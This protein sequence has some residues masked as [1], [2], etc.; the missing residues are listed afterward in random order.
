[1]QNPIQK[2]GQSFIVFK[3]PGIF[4]KNLKILMS[5]NYPTVQHFCWNF[6][7]VAYLPMSIKGCTGFFLSCLDLE[8]FAKK[9]KRPGIYTLLFYIFINNSRSRQNKTNPKYLFVDINK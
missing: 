1:M 4:S 6:A 9:L 7:H 8:L 5:S 3:K 2:F